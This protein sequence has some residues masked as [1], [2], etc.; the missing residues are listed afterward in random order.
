MRHGIASLALLALAAGAAAQDSDDLV[1]GASLPLSGPNAAAGQE[2]LAVMKAYFDA[3]NK[4]GGIHGRRIA[5]RALDD[6]FNPKT[7]ADNARQL[8]DDKVLAVFN[9]WGTASCSAM[10]P[11]ITEHRLPLVAGIAGGGPMRAA[12]GRYAF[13]VR[14]TTDDEIARMVRQM[15][16]VGQTRIAVV[17]QDDPFGKSGLASAQGVLAKAALPPAAEIALAP[18][19]G[20]A[21]AVV[22]ALKKSDANG[23][24][25]VGSPVPSVK[26]ITLARQGG[27]AT[28]FYNLAA[29]ANRKVAADLGEHT[30]GVIFTTLVPSPWRDALPVV[31]EYQQAYSAGSGKSDYS[32]LGLEVFI[33]AKVLVEGLRKAGRSPSRESL[34]AAL[35]SM[36][37]KNYGG[38]MSV[39]YGPGDREGS[40]YVGL[41]IINRQGR[42]VE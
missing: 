12:P 22:A 4:A 11:V 37:E 39:K 14:P 1:I 8:A 25:L 31:K 5:L 28:Q 34:V 29:Q 18:D 9:C 32:Y 27:I 2:G 17:Y 20:N 41:T 21:A 36:D 10:V 33:N 40:S 38:L 24:I 13:N 30:N 23:I 7:A 15:S 35:E 26:L 3:V 19:G 16:T 42:F 6:G